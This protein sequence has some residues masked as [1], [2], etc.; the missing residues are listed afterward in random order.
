LGVPTL[1][2]PRDL[3]VYQEIL[4]E[5]RPNL[6]I[7]TGTAFG[8]SA[9]FLASLCDI[10]GSGRVVTIDI[11]PKPERPRHERI[12]YLTGSSTSTSVVGQV[13]SMIRSGER[14]MA[15]LDSDHRREHV[16]QEVR[17]FGPLVSTGCY[18][19]VEDTN[20]NGHPVALCSGPDPWEA[21]DEFSRAT[22]IS[23]PTEARRR[24]S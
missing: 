12:T 11:S 2:C 22:T 21:L 6:I 10:L 7:E 1:K 3:W 19:A 16:L 15:I 13:R 20:I 9:L 8:G 23:W 14:V 4:F 18:L 17:E 5:T 24:A